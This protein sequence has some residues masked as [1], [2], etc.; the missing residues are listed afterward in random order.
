MKKKKEIHGNRGSY[1][2]A[3]TW[4]KWLWKRVRAQVVKK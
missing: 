1:L 3:L 4:V 2:G